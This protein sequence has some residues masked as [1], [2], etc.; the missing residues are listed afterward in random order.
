MGERH[1]LKIIGL[2]FM[3]PIYVVIQLCLLL[4]L[5][6][7]Q[8]QPNQVGYAHVPHAVVVLLAHLHVDLLL[9]LD[10]QPLYLVLLLNWHF[11][12]AHGGCHHVTVLVILRIAIYIILI[13]TSTLTFYIIINLSVGLHV[14]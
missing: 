10:V 1:L 2:A 3:L 11:N 9:C 5:E 12:V 8:S 14:L 7:V 4:L 13:K 6:R